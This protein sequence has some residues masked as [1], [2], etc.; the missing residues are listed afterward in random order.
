[1]AAAHRDDA[2]EAV[3]VTPS[4]LVVDVLHVAFDDLERIVGVV[5]DDRRG[6]E[7]FPHPQ[8]LRQGQTIVRFWRV[9]VGGQFGR[10]HGHPFFTSC[11]RP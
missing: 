2:G 9:V 5:G 4:G 3:E 6:E 10:V 8:G 1:V 11:L 7:L